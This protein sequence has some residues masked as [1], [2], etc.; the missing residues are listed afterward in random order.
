MRKILILPFSVLILF[1]TSC[2]V[3]FVEK[4]YNVHWTVIAI[5]VI[6]IL[7]IAGASLAKKKYIC[8]NCHKSFYTNW[9]KC[10]FSGHVNDERNLRCP[11]CKQVG[12]CYPSYNQ[13][14]EK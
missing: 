8:P 6:I 2:E 7:I 12:S 9:F 11:H 10:L 4:T 1:L 14:D 5:P 13:E 3:H